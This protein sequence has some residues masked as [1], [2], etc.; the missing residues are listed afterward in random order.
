MTITQLVVGRMYR[1]VVADGTLTFSDA[2]SD[3]ELFLLLSIKKGQSVVTVLGPRKVG[4]IFGG[5]ADVFQE[6]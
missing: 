3:G 6:P 2:L 4:S 1:Y 5:T